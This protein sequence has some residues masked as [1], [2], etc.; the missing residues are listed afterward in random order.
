MTK[1]F[2]ADGRSLHFIF[3]ALVSLAPDTN[4]DRETTVHEKSRCWPS[5]DEK[6]RERGGQEAKQ[7]QKTP[8][9]R[10]RSTLNFYS[11]GKFFGKYSKGSTREKEGEKDR[12][13]A[14]I[15]AAKVFTRKSPAQFT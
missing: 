7:E 8:E 4:A 15:V 13:A 12:K 14:S 5:A 1:K 9:R 2:V 6:A 3:R 11:A 10:K